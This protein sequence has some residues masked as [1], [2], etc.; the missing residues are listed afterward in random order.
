METTPKKHKVLVNGLGVLQVFIGVGAV[1]GGLALVLEPDG[2]NIGIPVEILKSSPFSSFLVPGIVLLIVNGF[3]S[4]VGA[5]AS[6]TRYWFAG[7]IAIAL[8][9][10]LIVWIMLQVYWFAGFHWLHALYL[11]IGFSELILGWLL[12]EALRKEVD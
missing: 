9:L 2:S 5:L 11:G 1:G 4:L 6:F 7:E 3:G 8:G 10:F 12:R